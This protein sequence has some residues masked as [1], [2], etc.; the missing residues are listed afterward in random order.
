MIAPAGSA[1]SPGTWGLYYLF[2]AVRE[3]F[4]VKPVVREI[5]EVKL[6]GSQ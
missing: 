1:A 3:M 2:A 6:S 5:F 4:E